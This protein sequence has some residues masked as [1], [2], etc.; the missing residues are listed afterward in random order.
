VRQED[1]LEIAAVFSF[2]F[3]ESLK[4]AVG[5]GTEKL[6]LFG[7]STEMLSMFDRL[8][9]TAEQSGPANI[10]RQGKWLVIEIK[11]VNV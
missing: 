6:K 9:E 3:A 10:Y 8:V 7:R 5:N 1:L 4:M 2:A 11:E